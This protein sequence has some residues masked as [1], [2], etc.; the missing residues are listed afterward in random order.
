[1]QCFLHRDVAAVGICRTCGKGI[2]PACAREIDRGIVCSEACAQF[3]IVTRE[4]QDR[5]KRIYSIGTRLKI[6]V[7][8]WL[9]G[10]LGLLSLIGST[11]LWWSD[12]KCWPAVAFPGAVGLL[13][14]GFSVF[15]WRRYRAVG[16]SL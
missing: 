5:A 12:P 14:L 16:L 15:I 6:P 9:Y 4:L 8:A 7:G 10:I 11:V 3:A 1:M 13:F 2:C